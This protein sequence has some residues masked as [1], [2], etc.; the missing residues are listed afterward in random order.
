[1]RV[2][3]YRIGPELEDEHYAVLQNGRALRYDNGELTVG[4]LRDAARQYLAVTG[5]PQ[6]THVDPRGRARTLREAEIKERLQM[7]AEFATPQ[8]L[9][10]MLQRPPGTP[11]AITVDG[12]WDFAPTDDNAPDVIW[13]TEVTA[14]LLHQAREAF[15]R[16][17][18]TEA[19]ERIDRIQNTQTREYV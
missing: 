17:T 1:M 14:D 9:A 3:V 15:I 10:A 2:S 4:T 18:T 5:L 13:R 8:M 12:G 6:E 19:T 11:M 16:Q 7:V